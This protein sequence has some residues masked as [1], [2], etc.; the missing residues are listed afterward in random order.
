MPIVN[1]G[2]GGPSAALI[3]WTMGLSQSQIA[4]SCD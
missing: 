1:V 4:N 2:I 3:F